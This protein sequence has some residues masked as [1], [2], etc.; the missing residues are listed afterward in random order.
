MG[1]KDRIMSIDR[2]C[3]PPA[4]GSFSDSN[5]QK[6]LKLIFGLYVPILCISLAS[7]TQALSLLLIFGYVFIVRAN[8]RELDLKELLLS[9]DLKLRLPLAHIFMLCLKGVPDLINPLIT[10]RHLALII[11]LTLLPRGIYEDAALAL[12]FSQDQLVKC[13]KDLMSEF[14]TKDPDFAVALILYNKNVGMALPEGVLSHD[15]IYYLNY[16][17]FGLNPNNLLLSG[18]MDLDSEE[19]MALK[20]RLN[21]A[22]GASSFLECLVILWKKA[23][24][25]R[26]YLE[27]CLLLQKFVLEGQDS[28]LKKKAASDQKVLD[29]GGDLNVVHEPTL[30][31]AYN[32]FEIVI[33]LLR[34]YRS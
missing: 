1:R 29:G 13:L 30:I 26:N 19:W 25:G 32:I 3:P 7:L 4:G 16:V 21:K 33:S 15:D 22:L 18:S 8:G 11:K 31:R 5:F 27:M 2:Y 24:N 34:I 14:K 9:V 10:G 12:K 28:R 17:L 20:D 23:L 6:I